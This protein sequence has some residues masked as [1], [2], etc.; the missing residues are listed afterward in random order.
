MLELCSKPALRFLAGIALSLG[1]ISMHLPVA[2]AQTVTSGP[3]LARTAPAAAPAVQAVLTQF[4][5]VRQPD[6]SEKLEDASKVKPGDV[7]EYQV[8]YVNNSPR[9]V[10][11]L[12]ASLPIPEGPA[13]QAHSAKPGATVA[14]AATRDG[15]FSAEP[16]T[17]TVAGKSVPVPY[18]DYR[19]IQWTLGQLPAHGVATVTARAQVETAGLTPPLPSIAT[20]SPGSAA[21]NG[22]ARQVGLK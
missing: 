5:V 12:V 20:G 4:K 21:A 8:S 7:I 18:S 3:A 14:K 9:A 17:R 11:T 15:V 6:G 19:Q 16:L 1:G 10:T 22:M 13:Y 2:Q